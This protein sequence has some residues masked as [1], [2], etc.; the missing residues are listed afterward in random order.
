[1]TIINPVGN[2]LTGQTGTG[3]FVGSKSPTIY[4]TNGNKELTFTTTASAVNYLT[5][6]NAATGNGPILAA[7]GT[8]TNA[9][10]VLQGL[11]NSGVAT[12][13]TSTNSTPAAGYVGEIIDSGALSLASFTASS[14]YQPIGSISI[15]AGDWDIFA[16]LQIVPTLNTLN[17]GCSI[18][19]TDT[20]S[21]PISYA[22]QSGAAAAPGASGIGVSS[23][24]PT[25]WI[26]VASNTTI[27]LTAQVTT[28]TG[29]ASAFGNLFARRVR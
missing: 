3:A 21:T 15:T 2:S 26:R 13:G 25:G 17:T 7:N 23:F 28:S 18:S 8:D 24:H 9:P 20:S 29:N 14:T 10:L 5:I 12:Q 11:G 27:Y 16:F 19:T 6:T 4:D 22:A 1:M